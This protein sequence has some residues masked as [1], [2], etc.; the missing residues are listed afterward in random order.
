MRTSLAVSTL[1]VLVVVSTASPVLTAE[2]EQPSSAGARYAAEVRQ[3]LAPLIQ[4]YGLDAV[5]LQGNLLRYSIDN[6]SLLEATVSISGTERRDGLN[7]LVFRLDTGMVFK[8]AEVS[9]ATRPVRIWTDVLEPSL[10]HCGTLE[11]S[12]DGIEIQTAY[13]HAEF[14][15]RADLARRIQEGSVSQEATVFAFS[16]TDIVEMAQQRIPPQELLRRARIT[17][18]GK[19]AR[20]PIL[21]TDLEPE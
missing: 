6:G 5:N 8:D 7:Y 18:D 3:A 12:G 16:K 20:I 17:V 4:Q 21:S 10:Q 13:R 11:V 14:A 19:P 2:P 1:I 9:P 15:D